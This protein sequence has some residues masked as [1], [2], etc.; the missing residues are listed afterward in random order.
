[1]YRTVEIGPTAHELQRTKDAS[2]TPKQK[3]AR[4]RRR[5]EK[6][7]S[8]WESLICIDGYLGPA[9][10]ERLH[11]IRELA[12]ANYLPLPEIV[13]FW[14]EVELRILEHRIAE[15]AQRFPLLHEMDA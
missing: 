3:A 15:E 8:I 1:M 13:E 4:N 12:T 2:I 6:M 11:E 10:R 5:C 9:Q 14:L 7:V